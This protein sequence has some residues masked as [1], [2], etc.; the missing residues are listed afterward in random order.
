MLWGADANVRIAQYAHSAWRLQD[1]VISGEPF[2]IAQTPDGY[3][4]VG[5]GNGL[6][7]F[8]GVRFVPLVST[9]GQR[10][11]KSVYS[12]LPGLDGS[13][14]IGTGSGLANLKD[15]VLKSI[16]GTSGRVNSVIQDRQGVIWF[17]RSR[18]QDA[19]GPLCK[20]T[21]TLKCYGKADG[22]P[23]PYAGPLTEDP[24]GNLW[25]G[26]PTEMARWKPG[27]VAIFPIKT[28]KSNEG[29]NGVA[30][31]VFAGDGS[32]WVGI[33]RKGRQLGLQQF[34]RGK[35]ASFREKKLD[36]ETLSV[37]ALYRDRQN[38]LWVGTEDQGI[39]RIHGNDVDH[40]GAVDGLSSDG[41]NAFFED[42]EGNM[43]VATSRGVECFRDLKVTSLTAQEGLGGNRP[44]PL[45][46]A[47]D[48]TVWIG[49]HA[50]LDYVR[51]GEVRSIQPKDGL[52]GQRVTS[53]FEDREGQLWIGTDR[54]LFAYA[55]GK[56]SPIRR[57][58]GGALGLVLSI[59]QDNDGNVWAQ[60][61]ADRKELVRIEKNRIREEFTEPKIPPASFLVAAH[62]G[63]IWLGLVNGDLALYR[64]GRLEKF[65]FEE[66]HK[67][68]AIHQLIAIS[69]G[70]VIGATSSGVIGLRGGRL[71]TL[72]ARNGLP[73]NR[74]YALVFDT[75]DA[76]WLYS[77]CG[78][79]RIA[80]QELKNWW[81]HPD[82]KIKVS[83]LD[84]FDGVQPSPP[85]FQPAAVRS[86]DGRLW[87][88]SES[89]VQ[90]VDPE[91][92]IRNSTPPPVHIEQLVANRKNYSPTNG[93]CLPPHIRDLEIDYTALSFVSPAK[94]H[95]RYQL[96][97]RD[98]GWQE[99][100]TRRQA[101]YTDLRPGSYRFRVIASNNDG[102]WNEQGASLDFSV[103]PAWYQT[104]AFVLLCILVAGVSAYGFYRLRMRQVA[105][106]LS[107]RFDERLV[108]RT[109]VAREL[110]D[111]LLQTVQGSKLV[112]D[113]ALENLSDAD[114]MR[115]AVGQLSLWLGRAVDE[116]R[117]AL[118]SLRASTT[119]KNNLAEAFRGAIEDCRRQYS[120]EAVF[121]VA[122]Q[123]QELHP[124]LRDEIYRIGYEA[125][126]NA[127]AHSDGTLMEVTLS[128]ANNLTVRVQDNG[129]GID[130]LI[131]ARGREG[132]F[133]LQ[134]MR[135]RA[136]RIGAK[137]TII[138]SPGS[139][140]EI[141]LV[142]PG[143]IVFK[144]TKGGISHWLRKS[145]SRKAPTNKHG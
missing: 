104:R 29:L 145:F 102:V 72:T 116:G 50:A 82:A 107:T 128:Y 67:P 19:S 15:G 53:L 9:D 30:A 65:E 1:G 109:R 130:P 108:E 22:I 40:F 49:N 105:R 21:T 66:G 119:E 74:V 87:F 5:T 76:L 12:L 95:F 80:D 8:D 70:T 62:E 27:S 135:E 136:D 13:L 106:M 112:A 78:L 34:L 96:E 55:R 111:T 99:P 38:T 101:F 97:G 86:T 58:D 28:H 92:P 47:K 54:G 11:A 115:H 51:Q 43:W 120:V 61:F 45:L 59:S 75:Q 4:W 37:T 131:A 32:L 83:V 35:W 48:G 81:D 134:G 79:V 138:S 42:R 121:S 77:Q 17:A 24:L 142:V 23:F 100:G 2:A 137:L 127:C 118:N 25:T 68:G 33:G 89:V 84:G 56:Y 69:D 7:R 14:W 3:V 143:R 110:H 52:P 139:G 39:Y 114:R 31:L 123:P 125:I 60:S 85:T 36:G 91:H 41:I 44:G 90:V 93:I 88:A 94:V 122:G 6:L 63:G 26:D 126:I 140:T 73:C 16:P 124:M 18:V 113:D 144:H 46:A 98:K 132:H 20:V 64:H 57:P 129:K 71:Q 141:D 117:A 10:F 103:T 133:G